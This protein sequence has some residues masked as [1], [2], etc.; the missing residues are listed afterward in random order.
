MQASKKCKR[1]ALQID[2]WSPKNIKYNAVENV[3]IAVTYIHVRTCTTKIYSLKMYFLIIMMNPIAIQGG[4]GYKRP[5]NLL[6]RE[7]CATKMNVLH[8][9][10]KM[11]KINNSNNNQ[12]T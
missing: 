12:A 2:C 11:W 10:R 6:K 9:I 8:A 1:N 4:G 7:K 3:E 5:A